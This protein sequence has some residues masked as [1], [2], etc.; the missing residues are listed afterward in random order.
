[1]ATAPIRVVLAD[2]HKMFREALC[3]VLEQQPDLTIVGEAGNGREAVRLATELTPDVLIVDVNMPELN[4]IDAAR[5]VSAASPA[6]RIIALTM[7]SD[8][9]CI[10]EMLKAGA[11]AYLLKDDGAGEL[12]SALHA[13]MAN[14]L[15]LSPRITAVALGMSR[16][17][18]RAGDPDPMAQLTSGE[19]EVLQ[20][21]AE[22]RSNKQVAV[23]LCLSIKTI[24]THRAHLMQKTGL[25]S[26]ALLMK[27]AIRGGLS[28]L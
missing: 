25:Y 9:R 3:S 5:Q 8:H 1:M 10:I 13:V 4:G 11:T 22:G 2:D 21:L 24:E 16:A 23:D 26:I 7:R 14:D 6:T 20:L 19:R 18:T 27:Y 12:V 17:A 28:G 15:Y